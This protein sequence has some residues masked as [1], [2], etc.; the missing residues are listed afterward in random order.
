MP[1]CYSALQ[2]HIR[3]KTME[4]D[5]R[6]D[7][8]C[9]VEFWIW[10]PVPFDFDRPGVDAKDFLLAPLLLTAVVKQTSKPALFS[11]SRD[12]LI[13]QQHVT[14]LPLPPQRETVDQFLS[15]VCSCRSIRYEAAR[16]SNPRLGF[17]ELALCKSLPLCCS[18]SS[19]QKCIK[20]LSQATRAHTGLAVY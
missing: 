7:P 15:H 4:C 8:R 16:S 10:P 13:K 20:P 11:T 14:R 2:I 9:Q 12:D 19:K 3:R 6:C 5:I 1:K 17:A 18:R